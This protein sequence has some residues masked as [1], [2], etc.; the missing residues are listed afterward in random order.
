MSAKQIHTHTNKSNL[1]RAETQQ[2][3]QQHSTT[4]TVTALTTITTTTAAW[5]K[6]TLC[7]RVITFSTNIVDTFK[8]KVLLRTLR[9]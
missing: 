9:L 6:R 7:H 2:Q 4:T 8:D 5:D 1:Q 3:Q